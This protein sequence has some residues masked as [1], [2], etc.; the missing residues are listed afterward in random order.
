MLSIR[1]PKEVLNSALKLLE[2]IQE[3]EGLMRNKDW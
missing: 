3:S 1:V 2:K